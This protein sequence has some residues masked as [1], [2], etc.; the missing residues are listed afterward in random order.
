MSFSLYY[1]AQRS[2][3]LSDEEKNNIDSIVEKYCTEYPFREKVEDFCAYSSLEGEMN[4]FSGSTKLPDSGV[5]LMYEVALYW[6]NCLSKITIV[7]VD[8]KWNVS[9]DDINLIW[10]HDDS[11]RFPTDEEYN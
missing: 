1:S 11:W 2:T 6:L 9:F 5:E 8:C 10:D 7:L 3:V 4:I